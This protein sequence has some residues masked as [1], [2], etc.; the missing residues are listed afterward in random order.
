MIIFRDPCKR[1]IVQP[2]CSQECEDKK[3]Y[4]IK[5]PYLGIALIIVQTL[6]I[7]SIILCTQIVMFRIF[8][9]LSDSDIYYT[10]HWLIGSGIGGYIMSKRVREEYKAD[11]KRLFHE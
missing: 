6:Y 3:V 5:T 10:I 2:M 7:L 9:S 1:C 8:P 4:L 11:R